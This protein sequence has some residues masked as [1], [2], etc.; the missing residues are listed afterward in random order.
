M[1]KRIAFASTRWSALTGPWS[2][3]SEAIRTSGFPPPEATSPQAEVVRT[4]FVV[5]P[6]TL[7]QA[8]PAPAASAC[9]APIE[10]RAVTLFVR[11]SIRD[12]LPSM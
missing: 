3:K 1:T 9:G 2:A 12:T 6:A 10:V 8:T 5:P 11:G 7:T 4:P